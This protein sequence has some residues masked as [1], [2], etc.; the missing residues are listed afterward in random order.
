M[1]IYIYLYDI[2][3][4]IKHDFNDLIYGFN[5]PEFLDSLTCLGRSG[6]VQSGRLPVHTERAHRPSDILWKVGTSNCGTALSGLSMVHCEN[7]SWSNIWPCTALKNALYIQEIWW[8]SRRQQIVISK[9]IL[10]FIFPTGPPKDLEVPKSR[11]QRR[12]LVLVAQPLNRR[13]N[14][15]ET[16]GA[17]E[18]QSRAGARMVSQA[19]ANGRATSYGKV[20]EKK[21]E[22]DD[23]F[24]W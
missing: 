2:D 18:A 21:E 11:S 17:T 23:D 1:Y 4:H 12:G 16:T 3:G 6:S 8:T 15:A 20:K 19:V 9:V 5:A 13:W 14:E 7:S 22:M 24:W 10:F